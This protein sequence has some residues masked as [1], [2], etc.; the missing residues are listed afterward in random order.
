MPWNLP[1]PNVSRDVVVDHRTGGEGGVAMKIEKIVESLSGM[2][3]IEAFGTN[4]LPRLW[5]H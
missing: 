4:H 1:R 2:V 5:I 3:I